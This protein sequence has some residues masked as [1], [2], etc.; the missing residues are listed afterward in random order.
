MGPKRCLTQSQFL[1]PEDPILCRPPVAGK[2]QPGSAHLVTQCC[3][4]EDYCNLAYWP[5]LYPLTSGK[6]YSPPPK[7]PPELEI[8]KSLKN[9]I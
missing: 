5:T 8:N 7:D 1:P 4:H 9:P 6:F 2:R 3:R